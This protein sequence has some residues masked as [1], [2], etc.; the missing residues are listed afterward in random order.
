MVT[1]RLPRR[2]P[3]NAALLAGLLV[4]IVVVPNVRRVAPLPLIELFFDV[5]LLTGVISVGPGRH[6]LAFGLLT[7][8]TL[9]AR[10]ADII[11]GHTGFVFT[12]A[13]LSM[14]WV[15]YAV[16]IIVPA[17]FLR[18]QVTLDTIFGAVIVYLLAALAFAF[19][20]GLIEYSAPGSFSGLPEEMAGR[21]GL[22]SDAMMY[23]SLVSITTMGYGDIVP[24]SELARS[25]AVLEGVFGQLYL[26]VMIARLVGLHIVHERGDDD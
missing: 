12:S 24:V 22:T 17:L 10:W 18:R 1:L 20:F 2:P 5:V 11:L 21:P 9:G 26:A 16:V 4:L 8:V 7:L 19:A 6:R 3:S 25:F 13:A 23:F 14:V 15:A